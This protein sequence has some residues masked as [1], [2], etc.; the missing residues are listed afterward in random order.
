MQFSTRCV[1]IR[2]AHEERCARVEA[3]F[4]V[5]RMFAIAAFVRRRA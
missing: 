4:V 2:Q 5:A 3:A 1:Q